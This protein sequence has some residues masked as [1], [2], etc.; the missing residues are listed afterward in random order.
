[1]TDHKTVDVPYTA[2]E[3]LKNAIERYVSGRVK[4][5]A[6]ILS[7]T[8]ARSAEDN[9]KLESALD[10]LVKDYGYCRKCADEVLKEAEETRDFLKEV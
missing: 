8:S 6:R 2:F 3:P 10:R 9:R 7:S 4:D 5:T 1:M